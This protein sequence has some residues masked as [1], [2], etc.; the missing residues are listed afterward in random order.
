MARTTPLL[1]SRKNFTITGRIYV[2]AILPIG[3]LYT[4][5]LAC[6]NQ[7]Y[8]YLSVPFIQ[9]LKALAPVCTLWIS[10]LWGLANPTRTTLYNIV[11]ITFGVVLSSLGE[12]QFNWIGFAF[13]MAGIITESC[14]LLLIQVLLKG[15]GE[16]GGIKM[17]PLVGLYYYAPICAV[18]NGVVALMFEFPT[19]KYEDF[20]RVGVLMLLLNCLVAFMLNIAS[21]FLV[22]GRPCLSS[23]YGSKQRD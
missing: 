15:E 14:R 22:S 5:S 11:L 16:S 4:A 18:L 1:D 6:S 7:T 8:L 10:W 21:V 19:F 17:D 2:R 3:L 20:E 9:M 23:T 13:Q 12:V